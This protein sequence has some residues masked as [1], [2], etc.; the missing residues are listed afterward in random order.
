MF[1]HGVNDYGGKFAMHADK[2]LDAGVRVYSG[3]FQGNQQTDHFVSSTASSCLTCLLTVAQL[4]SMCTTP[5][6]KLS[7]G[8]TLP[9]LRI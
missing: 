5:Q 2:F 8:L 9:T 3:E 1:L 6:W 7:V 4:V